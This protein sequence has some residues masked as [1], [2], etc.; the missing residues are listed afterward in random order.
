MARLGSQVFSWR[1]ATRIPSGSPLK[2]AFP[3]TVHVYKKTIDLL[4]S[5]GYSVA[6][7]WWGQVEKGIISRQHPIYTLCGYIRA[8][9]WLELE[10]ELELNEFLLRDRIIDLLAQETWSE[11]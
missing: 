7:A 8:S 3:S 10:R 9:E 2:K 6:I 11:D 5:W 4:N 1:A